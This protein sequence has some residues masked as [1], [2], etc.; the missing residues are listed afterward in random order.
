MNTLAIPVP[1]I[2]IDDAAALLKSMIL[3]VT[4]G[5]LSF[6]RTITD[7]PFAVLVT[8][9]I[10]PKESFLC[11]AVNFELLKVSP[12]AVAWPFNLSE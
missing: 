4:N 1:N 7:F 12:L 3:P 10:V 11:A 2:P 9:T 5:P 6:T 8:L